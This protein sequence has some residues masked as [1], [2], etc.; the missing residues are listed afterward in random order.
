M[1]PLWGIRTKKVFTNVFFLVLSRNNQVT[2]EELY[3]LQQKFQS[4]KMALLQRISEV[5]THLQG[6]ANEYFS[7]M[8]CKK[9]F[10]IS[11][12]IIKLFR[13]KI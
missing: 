1:E 4:Q 2:K 11:S 3:S 6:V 12:I 7:R 10:S 5:Q 9:I 8:C 13:V